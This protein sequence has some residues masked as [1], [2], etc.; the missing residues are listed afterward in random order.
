MKRTPVDAINTVMEIVQQD[1]PLCILN[2]KVAYGLEEDNHAHTH[3][4][5]IVVW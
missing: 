2:D 4:V 3:I 5:K 1:I